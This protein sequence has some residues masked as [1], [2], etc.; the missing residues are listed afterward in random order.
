MSDELSW[1]DHMHLMHD[2]AL[3]FLSEESFDMITPILRYAE[4]SEKPVATM[5]E[6]AGVV[7]ALYVETLERVCGSREAARQCIIDSTLIMDINDAF[8]PLGSEG[9][10]EVD[11]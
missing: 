11:P 7:L 1:L 3:K 8:I 9:V 4:A 10:D 5:A 2:L 6:A